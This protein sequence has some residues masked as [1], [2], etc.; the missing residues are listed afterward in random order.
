LLT[1]ANLAPAV[2]EQ[3]IKA[4]KNV[5][6]VR[7]TDGGGGGGIY[8]DAAAMKLTIDNQAQSL[9]GDWRYKVEALQV[10]SKLGPNSY[11]TL[12]FNSMINP[13]IPYAI[14][15][16]IWYQGETNTGRAYQ[17]R[18]AFPLMIT[19]WRSRWNQG[20]FPFYFVQLA[21]FNAGNGDTQK[22]STWAELREAQTNTLSLP[23]T[24]M[25]VTIDIGESKDIHPRN[26][27]DVGK[28]LAAIALNNTYQ[29][30]GE[31]SGPAYQS[32]KTI[33]NKIELTFTHAASG[34]MAKDKY[35]YIKGFEIAGADQQFYFA[36]AQ[37]VGDKIVV[38]SD[39]V[40]APVAVRYA[41]ADDMPEANLYN[42]EGFPAL[43]FRTDSWKGITE[44]VRYEIK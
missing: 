25:A 30:N 13:L 6:T 7:V 15:G 12:L 43:P 1:E 44:Q 42:K 23:N 19:D 9:A 3:V 21:S 33:G 20:D 38:Y 41:W 11:P 31:Y 10:N 27:Q 22:G 17:Y 16:A 28:R 14:G 35:S 18:K 24:G 37:V 26:K 4:G 36:Q 29:K 2:R 34:F 40:A 32:M 39:K 5:I 8:G